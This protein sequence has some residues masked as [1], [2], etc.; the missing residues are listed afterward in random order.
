M[1]LHIA[2]ES[3]RFPASAKV[4]G[5]GW[6]ATSWNELLWCALTIGR[7]DIYHVF[8]HGPASFHEAI[9]RLALVRLAVEQNPKGR[10][11]RTSAFRSLD[12]TEKGMVSYFL[13]MTLCKLFASRFLQTPWLLHLDV[14]GASLDAKSLGRSRPD[15]IG[16]DNAG[17]WHAFESKGRSQSPS[18]ADKHNAK[19]QAQR[20]VSVGGVPS[21]LHIGAVTFFQGDRLKFYW[22]DPA[23]DSDDT[24]EVPEPDG[25]WRH[26]YAP[27]LSFH[28]LGGSAPSVREKELADVKV[29]IHPKILNLLREGQWL[30]ARTTATEM[31]DELKSESYFADGLRVFAGSSWGR[32]FVRAIDDN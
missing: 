11:D 22:R 14:F 19:L 8:R 24:I 26:Y 27:A 17:N 9:F 15:L 21:T 28:D 5:S 7:P 23:A 12:P 29:E 25:E 16:E 4:P 20:L 31:A 30:M 18:T 1:T 13:G 10:L 32:P 3:E 6:L 2:F